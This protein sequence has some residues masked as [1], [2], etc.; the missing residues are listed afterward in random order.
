MLI[1]LLRT[2][3]KIQ[4]EDY[5]IFISK[6]HIKVHLKNLYYS[7]NFVKFFKNLIFTFKNFA[8]VLTNNEYKKL[9]KKYNNL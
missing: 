5:K 1:Y 3:Q 4:F 7:K 8:I 2:F 6:I 9:E